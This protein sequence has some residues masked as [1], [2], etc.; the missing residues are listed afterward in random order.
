MTL[1]IKN[2]SPKKTK[3]L[4]ARNYTIKEN[5]PPKTQLKSKSRNLRIKVKNRTI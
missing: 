1:M 3:L 4:T 5:S 2:K